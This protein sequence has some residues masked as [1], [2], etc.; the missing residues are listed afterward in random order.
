[1]QKDMKEISETKVARSCQDIKL[2]HPAATSGT[3]TID[4]N[5]GSSLDA[6]KTYCDFEK[7]S[8]HTCVKNATSFT[9]INYLHLLHTEVSQSIRLP[10]TAQGP[11]RLTPFDEDDDAEVKLT[12]SK[13]MNVVLS[14]CNPF[15]MMRE[16]E[17]KSSNTV[18][19]TL[20]FVQPVRYN[21]QD[22]FF[23]DICF[24]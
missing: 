14:N 5:L 16:V 1:M 2:E 17:F 23:Q 8:A 11:F 15:S 3:Y 18:K 22:Y 21:Y 24:N 19:K 6:I 9:Q 20:P 7:K 10:C 4:P 12:K 13:D